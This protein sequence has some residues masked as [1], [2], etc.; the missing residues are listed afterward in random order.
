[1]AAEWPKQDRLDQTV[2]PHCS[3]DCSNDSRIPRRRTPKSYRH[4]APNRRGSGAHPAATAWPPSHG[5]AAQGRI[6]ASGQIGNQEK[7]KEKDCCRS[8][9]ETTRLGKDGNEN[10]QAC[11]TGLNLQNRGGTY[12]LIGG[13]PY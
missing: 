1:M 6:A 13:R 9:Q 12:E 3:H 10:P 7:E 11:V 4:S 8:S 5:K 2:L